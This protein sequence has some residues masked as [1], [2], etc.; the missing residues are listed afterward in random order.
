MEE[1]SK[2]SEELIFLLITASMVIWIAV[3]MELMKPRQQINM[4]K[5]IPLLTAG[6]LTT[7]LITMKLIQNVMS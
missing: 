5:I 6:S 2:M 4:R 7:I 1:W 3:S